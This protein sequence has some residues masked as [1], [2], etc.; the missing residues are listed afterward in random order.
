MFVWHDNWHTLGPLKVRFGHRVIY[1]SASEVGAKV[2]S[3]INAAGWCRF[4]AISSALM[5][6]NDGFPSYQPHLDRDDTI[7]WILI[8]DRSFSVD[9]AWNAIRKTCEVVPW[10]GLVWYKDAVPRCSFI[11]W[12][13]CKNRLRT[14]DRLR[15]WGLI[16]DSNCMFCGL[17]EESRNHLFFYCCCWSDLNLRGGGE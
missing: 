1:D 10:Y 11:F 8:K 3:L 7:E 9:S 4:P 2:D 15:R 6:I 5:Q 13:V 17:E 16:Q 14:R 12:L